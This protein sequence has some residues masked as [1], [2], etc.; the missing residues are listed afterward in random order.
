MNQGL[1][2]IRRTHWLRQ[3]MRRDGY[4]AEELINEVCAELAEERAAALTALPRALMGLNPEF[5]CLPFFPRPSKP[6]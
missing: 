3:K 1:G 4:T 2:I 5:A 6:R